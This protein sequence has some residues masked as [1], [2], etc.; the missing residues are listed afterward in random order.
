MR[1]LIS[2]SVIFLVLLFLT[3]LEG[4]SEWDRQVHT[5]YDCLS[6]VFHNED[7]APDFPQREGI[8]EEGP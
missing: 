6:E 5:T 4:D 3:P 2:L 1:A 7:Q 8:S